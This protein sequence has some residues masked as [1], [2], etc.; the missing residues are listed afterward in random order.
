MIPASAV[1]LEQMKLKNPLLEG[2][3]ISSVSEPLQPTRW[4]KIGP[5]PSPN[6]AGE[7]MQQHLQYR[8]GRRGEERRV[9]GEESGGEGREGELKRGDKYVHAL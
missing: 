2:Q 9:G 3:L 6:G 7:L 4:K 5:V 8:E 1:W